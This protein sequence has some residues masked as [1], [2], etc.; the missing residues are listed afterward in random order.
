MSSLPFPRVLLGPG[1][2]SV[3]TRVLN[4]LSMPPIGYLDPELL[5]IMPEIMKQLRT[6]FGTTNEFTLPLTGTGMAGMECCLTNLLEQGEEVVIG[7]NGFFGLRMVEIARRCGAKVTQVDF[8]WGTPLVRGTPKPT[9]SHD[10][11]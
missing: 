11:F 2:A 10:P 3:S 7:V 6:V 9:D 1:P 5:S 8:D 4:V